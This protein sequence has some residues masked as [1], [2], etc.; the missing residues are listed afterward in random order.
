M[1]CVSMGK[2][3]SQP[4]SRPHVFDACLVSAERGAPL[5]KQLGA[6][7][8]ASTKPAESIGLVVL[9]L[10]CYGEPGCWMHVWLLPGQELDPDG[11]SEEICD[12][13]VEGPSS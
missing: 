13:R 3:Q 10:C 5:G 6:A 2:A 7:A 1:T 8:V 12:Y 9:L 4:S 11:L